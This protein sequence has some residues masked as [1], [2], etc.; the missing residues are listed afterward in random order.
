[1]PLFK[2]EKQRQRSTLFIS[3]RHEIV[4]IQTK[5]QRQL[6]GFIMN[7]KTFINCRFNSGLL[8]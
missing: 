6:F 1:M 4:Q 8:Y 7:H 3:I 5:E 2:D